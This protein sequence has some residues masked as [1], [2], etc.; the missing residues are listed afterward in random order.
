MKM[1]IINH[2]SLQRATGNFQLLDWPYNPLTNIRNCIHH[3][4]E[5]VFSDSRTDD[6]TFRKIESCFTKSF[7]ISCE[8]LTIMLHSLMWLWLFELTNCNYCQTNKKWN[9]LIGHSIWDTFQSIY[10]W[11]SIKHFS[12]YF[13]MMYVALAEV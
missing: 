12:K 6:R 4:I 5:P 8:N 7:I 2:Y 11:I 9:A 3:L 13:L 10:S 1:H